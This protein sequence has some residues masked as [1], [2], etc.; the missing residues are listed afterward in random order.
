MA[1]GARLASSFAGVV[2]LGIPRGGVPVALEVAVGLTSP[3]DVVIVRKIGVPTH[4]ELA[5]G[6]IGEAGA[7]VV[8]SD[9][10]RSQNVPDEQFAE[11]VARE[12]DELERRV[13]LYRGATER[14]E[15]TGRTVVIVDDGIATGSSVRAR[16]RS[17]AYVERRDWSWQL[18]C[19]ALGRRR[20]SA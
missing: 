14:T 17:L 3:L 20:D 12:R 2:V 13:Q 16:A 8:E 5:M 15:I 4:R 11:V 1:L 7:T 10:V 9:V 6:A 19:R 18:P